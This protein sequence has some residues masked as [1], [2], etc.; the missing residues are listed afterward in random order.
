[1]AETTLTSIS[2]DTETNLYN[3]EPENKP[4]IE[5]SYTVKRSTVIL[6]GTLVLALFLTVA[7]LFTANK[8]SS[9]S[10]E[11]V[12]DSDAALIK[13]LRPK[14]LESR[15]IT[16]NNPQLPPIINGLA[17]LEYTLAEI[18]NTQ[19]DINRSNFNVLTSE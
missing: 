8:I 3:I 10:Y 2:Q 14:T 18:E 7:V 16:E 1:M 4:K 11:S 12:T 13:S 15:G 9:D 6:I 5:K 19:N 17:G